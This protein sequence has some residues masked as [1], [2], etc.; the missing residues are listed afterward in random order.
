MYRTEK[1]ESAEILAHTFDEGDV[2]VMKD[3][4]QRTLASTVGVA[5]IGG[6]S[7][8]YVTLTL[9]PAP[10]HTGIVFRRVD[11]PGCPAI[12]ARAEYVQKTPLCS[13]LVKDAVQV[14][15]VEHML[16]ALAGS[17]VDNAYVDLAGS[18]VPILDG[19][20]AVFL[21]LIH[22]AGLQTQAALRRYVRIQKTIEVRQG[23]KWA[24]FES[25]DGQTFDVEISFAHIV[26][27]RS[28]Q[29]CCFDL[30]QGDYRREIARART[31][32]FM[33]DVESMREKGLSLGG[34]LQN[35][36]VLDNH[37]VLNKDGLRYPDE[38]VRHKLL[39]A[40]GDTY[41]LGHPF[42]GHFSAYK[43]GHA[44]NT[45]LVRHLLECPQA[46]TY[47]TPTESTVPAV[48]LPHPEPDFQVPSCA[49]E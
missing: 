8:L 21:L 16:S 29:R 45:L 11:L 47:Y 9:R 1:G 6:H 10:V 44:L 26:F 2:V 24:R 36:V 38:F 42:I 13:C 15:T 27:A 28:T 19:S 14:S 3:Q 20:S 37:R 35:A 32:A 48:S 25:A 31:F 34:N 17:G 33:R 23:D 4:W 43:T 12:P 39:D 7:G 40:I 49:M 22:R 30:W 5:G 41:L 18:E 46:F